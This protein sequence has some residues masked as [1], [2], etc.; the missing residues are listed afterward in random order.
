MNIFEISATA[1]KYKETM[2]TYNYY[3]NNDIS[4]LSLDQKDDLLE[5]LKEKAEYHKECLLDYMINIEHLVNGENNN[6]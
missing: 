5:V 6:D 3:K 1:E 4:W 2:L